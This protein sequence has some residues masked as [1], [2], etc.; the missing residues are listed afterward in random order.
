MDDGVEVGPGGGVVEDEGRQAGPVEAPVAIEHLGA[1]PLRHGRQAG[2][3]GLDHLPGDGV[4]VDDHRAA[5]GQR[6]GHRRLPRTDATTQTDTKHAEE[7]R[8][9]PLPHKGSEL[10]SGSNP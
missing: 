10:R 6:P 7:S 3:P 4:G 2:L 5:P 1:E 8:R 9:N